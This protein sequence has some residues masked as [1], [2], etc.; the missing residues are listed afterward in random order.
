MRYYISGITDLATYL[1]DVCGDLGEAERHE[2]ALALH[3]AE[4]RPRWGEDWTDW[5]ASDGAAIVA[6]VVS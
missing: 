4:G 3:G 5:L 2:A 6:E 1:D